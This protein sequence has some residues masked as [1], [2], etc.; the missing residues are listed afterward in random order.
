MQIPLPARTIALWIALSSFLSLVSCGGSNSFHHF[1]DSASI[2]PESTAGHHI[3]NV[4]LIMM[5]NHNWTGDGSLSIKGNYDAPYINRILVPM[6][7]HPSQYYNPP[8]VHPSLPNYLWLEAGTDFGLFNAGSISANSQSTTFHLVTLLKNAGISWR[9]YDEATN[10]TDCPLGQWHT[11]M[12]FFEDVTNNNDWHSS[13]CISHTRPMTELWRD[14]KN[15]TTAHY[16]FIK[17]NLCHSMHSRCNENQIKQGD[18]WLSEHIPLILN[19]DAYRNG[20]VIFILFD[21]AGLGDGPIPALILSPY[22]KKGYTNYNYYNHSSMLRTMQE[23]F[24]VGPLLRNA[25]REPD[26]RDFFTAFP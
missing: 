17:P 24:G 10:G 4:F 18:V 1:S 13:Y 20:G 16:S 3:K 23:I 21:E 5:E 12:L 25:A 7:A 11:P 8:H 9:S 14:L 26:L 2:E 19:S 22:A 15:N 6:G